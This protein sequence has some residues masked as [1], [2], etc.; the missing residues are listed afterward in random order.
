MSHS[1]VTIQDKKQIKQILDRNE[2]EIREFQTI[3]MSINNMNSEIENEIKDLTLQGQQFLT[4][5]NSLQTHFNALLVRYNSLNTNDEVLSNELATTKRKLTDAY[6][7]IENKFT[8]LSD[9]YARINYNS[10]VLLEARRNLMQNGIKV[11]DIIE[12][13]KRTR[14]QWPKT[15]SHTQSPSYDTGNAQA[16][17]ARITY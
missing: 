17:T 16:T 1:S 13:S 15:G 11:K 10:E 8:E 5:F 4:E 9:A 12:S 7:E 3:M 6:A 2:N 14:D